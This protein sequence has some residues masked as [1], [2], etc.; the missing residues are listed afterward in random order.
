M[1][2]K[3]TPATKVEKKEE[4]LEEPAVEETTETPEALEEK[5]PEILENG[6]WPV[7]DKNDEYI[8]TYSLKDHGEKA[9]EL[10]KQFADK[11]GGSVK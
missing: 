6:A 9:E 11:I 10:A 2:K 8:R 1:P 4:K 7:H 5:E 3:K